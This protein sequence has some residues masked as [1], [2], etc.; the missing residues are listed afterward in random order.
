MRRK[1]LPDLLVLILLLYFWAAGLVGLD[2][3]PKVNGDEP[4]I[5]A[6]GY[7]FWEKGVFGTDLFAGFYGAETHYFRP[8]PVFSLLEGAGLHLFGMGLF[9]ARIVS[10]TCIFL[11]LALTYRLGTTLFSRWHGLIVVA[12]LVGWRIAGVSGDFYSGIP[13]ADIARIA[14][15]DVAVPLFGF[16][17]LLV[18][19]MALRN[20]SMRRFFA[21]GALAGLAALS[22]VYGLFWLALLLILSLL[23]FR[24][25]IKYIAL[26]LIG[27]GLLMLPWLL[28]ITSDWADFINQNRSFSGRFNILDYRFYLNNILS[29]SQRYQPVLNRLKNGWGAELGL[30]LLLIGL[31][32]LVAQALK[33]SHVNDRNELV[34]RRGEPMCSPVYQSAQVT[35]FALGSFFSLFALFLSTKTYSYLVTLWP[36]FAL[37]AAAGWIAL[38]R[39]LNA[40]GWKLVL[41]LVF[42]A[43]MVE[44]GLR[45]NTI[46][47]QAAQTTPYRSLALIINSWLPANSRVMGLQDYWLGMDESIHYRS[48]LVPIDWTN[49][50]Y[51]AHPISFKEAAEVIPPDYLL[52]DEP[53]ID[54]ISEESNPDSG[55][56]DLARQ[57]DEYL[58]FR[59]G[60][61]VNQLNDPTYGRIYLFQLDSAPGR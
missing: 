40:C 13:M 48:I 39:F 20:P 43:V 51:V 37:V 18:F 15:Y 49:P 7:T 61:I 6:P 58:R 29:E 23:Y 5:A 42:Y 50:D 10:L 60:R 57:M 45:I 38:W 21:V 14:R 24:R 31:G 16:A 8:P 26:L 22:H 32:V 55:L 4:W 52:I 28:F 9:Q 46:Q 44:G 11:T 17:A 36:L 25:T 41:F 34:L 2:R 12:I 3:F 27:F 59:H 54:L 33:R 35:L 56:Y 1:R 19:V 30:A 53:I 47:K